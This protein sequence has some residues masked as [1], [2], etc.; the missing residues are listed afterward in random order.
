MLDQI[1]TDE[2]NYLPILKKCILVMLIFL[3]TD[4]SLRTDLHLDGN[5]IKFKKIT[6]QLSNGLDFQHVFIQ[7]YVFFFP[8][9]GFSL[10]IYRQC[11]EEIP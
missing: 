10:E 6:Q 7:G 2:P 1:S 5:T 11:P 3:V 8:L 9:W 4:G